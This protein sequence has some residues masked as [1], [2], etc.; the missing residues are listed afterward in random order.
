MSKEISILLVEDDPDT[1][2]I[3]YL[4]LTRNKYK[5]TTASTGLTGLEAALDPSKKYDII[6]TDLSMPTMSGSQM[7]TKL[8]EKGIKTPVIMLTAAADNDSRVKLMENGVNEVFQKPITNWKEIFRVI[9]ELVKE[10]ESERTILEILP[11]EE[12]KRREGER[13][14]REEEEREILERERLE[15]NFNK[16]SSVLY[17]IE[18]GRYI[19]DAKLISSGRGLRVRHELR[20][21]GESFYR[22]GFA[23]EFRLILAKYR[24]IDESTV[25]V[26]RI[27]NAP[28]YNPRTETISY[29]MNMTKRSQNLTNYLGR[30]NNEIF[31]GRTMYSCLSIAKDLKLNYKLSYPRFLIEYVS[32]DDNNQVILDFY[33]PFEDLI[34]E[35]S[36]SERSL[37]DI[38]NLGITLLTGLRAEEHREKTWFKDLKISDTIIEVITNIQEKRGEISTIEK[39]LLNLIR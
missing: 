14:R 3:F 7:T 13:E 6:L 33:N 34:G 35:D 19:H 15:E 37:K 1:R 28:S 2:E 25:K 22:Q 31:V 27:T 32:L 20:S 10:E 24:V 5:V 9:E 17:S 38:A 16:D 26:N 11:V 39:K 8:R 18:T 4:K 21:K 23:E 36:G 29:E 12:E 30:R